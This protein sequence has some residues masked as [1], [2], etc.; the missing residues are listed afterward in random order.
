M[1]HVR[2]ENKQYSTASVGY[3]V[4]RKQQKIGDSIVG[5]SRGTSQPIPVRKEGM[6][7]PSMCPR[8]LDVSGEKNEASR[9]ELS[10]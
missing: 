5:I 7:C 2:Q 3:S 8:T 10:R 9:L 1:G 4:F 6:L